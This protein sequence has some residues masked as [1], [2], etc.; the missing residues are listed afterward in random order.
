MAGL[1]TSLLYGNNKDLSGVD[2]GLFCNRLEGSMKG[3][4]AG[5]FNVVK[6]DVSGIQLG[7]FSNYSEYSLKGL[8]ISTFANM[9]NR[10]GSWRLK[11]GYGGWGAQISL[12]GNFVSKHVDFKGVQIGCYNSGAIKGVQIGLSN[13]GGESTVLVYKDTGEYARTSYSGYS[14]ISGLQ[15][16]AFSNDASHFAGVQMS[17][18]TNEAEYLSGAQFGCFNRVKAHKRSDTPTQN[19]GL[20]FGVVNNAVNFKGLQFGLI[21][22]CDR[23]KGLQIGLINYNKTGKAKFLPIVNFGF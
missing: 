13:G 5:G 20:Q 19:K 2:I 15:I 9:S 22:T 14:N 16:A 12:G 17:G 23:L 10:W 3:F 6:E 1:R 4:Q 11:K 21:N 8:Q 7:V 18:L